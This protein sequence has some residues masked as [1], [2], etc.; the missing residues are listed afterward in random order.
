MAW[1]NRL[2][3]WLKPTPTPEVARPRRIL[4]VS[5]LHLGEEVGSGDAPFV[6]YIAALNTEFGAFV[7]SLRAAGGPTTLVIDGDSFDFIRTVVQPNPIEARLIQ[8]QPLTPRQARLGLDSS[9]TYATW[10]LGRVIGFHRP[11]FEALGRFI[12]A[13]NDVVFVRGNHDVELY[14]PEVRAAIGDE[15]ARHSGLDAA[16]ASARVRFEPWFFYEPRLVYIEHGHQYDSHCSFTD[17]LDPVEDEGRLIALPY[18]LWSI[19]YFAPLLHGM[20][21]AEMDS[22]SFVDFA[23]WVFSQP[24]LRIAWALFAYFRMMLDLLVRKSWRNTVG[25]PAIH[26]RHMRRLAKLA[27]RTQLPLELVARI[28][29]LK[30]QPVDERFLGITLAYYLD[31]ILLLFLS[32]LIIVVTALLPIAVATRVAAICGVLIVTIALHEVTRRVRERRAQPRLTEKALLLSRL[33]DVPFV[34]FGHSHQAGIHAAPPSR[35]GAAPCHYY[36][37]SG[38]WVARYRGQPSRFNYV[39]VTAEG[40]VRR[41]RLMRWVGAG[42][43]PFEVG[44]AAPPLASDC[45]DD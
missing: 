5:D 13:G 40:A 37:N 18:A 28:D 2:V 42:Q 30:E 10:K 41:A 25:Q 12:G 1:W 14:W 16:T 43:P 27:E 34:V 20:P 8:A 4:V 39:E 17:L 21:A 24:P 11:V 32:L 9:R 3:G 44:V 26:A 33:V 7:D 15:I 45:R 19:R 22:W 36:L 29:A 31:R 38:H 23:R 6:E 35:P